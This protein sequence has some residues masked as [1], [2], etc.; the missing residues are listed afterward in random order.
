MSANQYYFLDKWFIPHPIAQVW[1]YIV[2]AERYPVWWGEVYERI[3]P[4]NHLEPDQLGA[5]ADVYAHGRLPY[6]IH[7]VSE[8]TRVEPPYQLGLAAQGDLN[9]TGLWML[10]PAEG[11]TAVS[12]EWIVQA[13][14]PILRI[15]SPLL[16][17]MFAWNHRWCMVKG[18]A[19]LIRLLANAVHEPGLVANE[20]RNRR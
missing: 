8:I 16:K 14:K 20:V 2:H 12:F 6:K 11:G 1:P 19:A 4:L 5:R 7:F 13:D 15:F 9:G 10:Q 17:P 18:E 3:T